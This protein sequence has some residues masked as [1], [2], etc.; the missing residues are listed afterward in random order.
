ML[1]ACLFAVVCLYPVLLMVLSSLKSN[2]Q[3]FASP[4]GLP[5]SLTLTSYRQL[6][7][8][9]P[10][11]GYIKNSVIVSVVAVFLTVLFGSMASFYLARLQFQMECSLVF[12]FSDGDDDS[13]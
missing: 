8:Q 13:H 1:I 11:F 12:L 10:Y 6:L 4:L 2:A 3:I 5:T 7:E 9:L